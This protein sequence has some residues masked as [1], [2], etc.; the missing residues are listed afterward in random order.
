MRYTMKVQIGDHKRNETSSKMDESVSIGL[1]DEGV[2]LPLQSK[3]NKT[4]NEIG[5]QTNGSL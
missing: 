1:G 4:I 3:K 5:K 2:M